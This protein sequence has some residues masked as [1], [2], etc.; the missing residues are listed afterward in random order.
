MMEQLAVKTQP[1]QTQWEAT[2][3]QMLRSVEV[4][5]P[6]VIHSTLYAAALIHSGPTDELPVVVAK[7]HTGM[8][9]RIKDV[10]R[11]NY[12][13]EVRDDALAEALFRNA[14]VGEPVPDELRGAVERVLSQVS[15]SV[16]RQEASNTPLQAAPALASA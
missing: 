5:D 4:G 11:L 2:R 13:P 6:I 7:G 16:R 8:A 15:P 14:K 1:R 9:S 12:I 3:Q 10:A